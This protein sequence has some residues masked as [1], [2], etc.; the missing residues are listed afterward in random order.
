MSGRWWRLAARNLG[1]HRRR[2]VLTGSIVVIGFIATTMTAGFVSQTFTGLRDV[3]IRGLGG[4]IRLVDP[5][6]AGK[7]DDE[8]AAFL[9]D[10]WQAVARGAAKDPSVVQAMPRLSFFGLVV[11]G[12]RSAAYL[13]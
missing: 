7:T 1:R 4:E 12:D 8:A 5:R 10:D 6:A 3:T 13:G 9:V 2:T 11:K